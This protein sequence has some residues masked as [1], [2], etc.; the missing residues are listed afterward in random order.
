MII[1]GTLKFHEYWHAGSGEGGIGDI[2]D[3]PV[4]DRHGLPYLPGKSL[5]GLLHEA[6][7]ELA[8]WPAVPSPIRPSAAQVRRLFGIES[9]QGRR[10]SGWLRVSNAV[11]PADLIYYLRENQMQGGLF[12]HIS[13]TAIE[14]SG[15]ALA[16]SLRRLE[17]AVPVELTFTLNVDGPPDAFASMDPKGMFAAAAKLIRRAGKFRN[18]G[19]GRCSVT[20]H[21]QSL[22]AATTPL[23]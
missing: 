20:C 16:R 12:E 5:K 2:D 9:N 6:F 4:R 3:T 19:F 10:D 8:A 21:T 14:E 22:P 1:E 17:V 15:I 23:S 7:C 18:N 11:L 13:S